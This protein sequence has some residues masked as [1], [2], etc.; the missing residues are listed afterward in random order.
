[1]LGNN[2][3]VFKFFLQL[4]KKQKRVE[5]YRRFWMDRKFYK[6]LYKTNPV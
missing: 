1:M 6:P 2:N 4:F 3:Q 5:F